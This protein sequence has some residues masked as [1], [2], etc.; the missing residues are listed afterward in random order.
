VVETALKRLVVDPGRTDADLRLLE[1]TCG[2]LKEDANALIAMPTARDSDEDMLPQAE[3]LF[4]YFGQVEAQI[5]AMIA[6]GQ[7]QRRE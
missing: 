7:D 2:T 4:R 3:A 6:T 5:A 1:A